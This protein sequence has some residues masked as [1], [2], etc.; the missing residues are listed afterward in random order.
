MPI[1][2]GKVKTVEPD[3]VDSELSPINT[4]VQLGRTE[5]KRTLIAKVC[6]FFVCLLFFY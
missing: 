3:R 1:K 5:K 4:R 2:Y 6:A